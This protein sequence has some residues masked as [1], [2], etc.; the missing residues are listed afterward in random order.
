LIGPAILRG[1]ASILI[2]LAGCGTTVDLGPTARGF[3]YG[4][5]RTEVGA[6][7]SVRYPGGW[8]LIG[9]RITALSFPAER[10]LLTSYPTS[11]GGN[12]SPERA[13]RDL[14]GDGALVYL[15][16]YR[17]QVG[18]VWEHLRRRD[19]P[20]QPA[21][22]AL[23]R[24]DLGSFECWRVPS[25]LIRFRA[26]ER[27][28]QMHVAL[29]TNATA[30]RRA[31]LLRILDSLRFSPLPPPPRD[32]YA[33]WRSLIDETGDSIRTPPRWPAA[34]ATSPRRYSR[35]RALFFA[36]NLALPGLAPAP[37]R[38]A[39]KARRL[40]SPFPTPALDAFPDNGILLW[41]REDPK[42][43]AS[44]TFPPLPRRRWPQADDFQRVQ[45]GPA[46][47][48]PQL[49]WERAAGEEQRHR[50]SVWVISAPGAIES[51]RALARKAA[52]AL[53][54]STGGFRDAPCRRACKTG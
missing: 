15:F 33:G 18:A 8:H 29:G 2:A 36:S 50:F 42:G 31:Q 35:P 53:A 26:A 9:P 49:R 51:D 40:P 5:P 43:P 39:R 38:S 6:G 11:R 24:R 41:V 14:P 32:P 4:G 30:V 7:V 37:P 19:F 16:E 20:P 48:W 54:L 22:F 10:L 23:R 45:T 28:F 3:S 17:P 12:C 46:R 1:L 21:H 27:P 44:D 34:V 25:Y 52:A 47:R 13:E